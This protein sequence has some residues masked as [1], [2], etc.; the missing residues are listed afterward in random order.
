MRFLMRRKTNRPRWM[1][2]ALI[3]LI[4]MILK[5]SSRIPTTSGFMWH[6]ADHDLTLVPALEPIDVVFQAPQTTAADQLLPLSYWIE[7]MKLTTLQ[8]VRLSRG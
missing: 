3:R 8:E 1:H 2:L 6:S 4:R 7:V 5:L